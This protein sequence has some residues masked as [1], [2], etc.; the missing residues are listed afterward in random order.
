MSKVGVVDM[1]RVLDET[2]L[3]KQ[4]AAE[5]KA[6]WDERKAAYDRRRE[7]VSIPGG[8]P[9]EPEALARELQQL[10]V[11]AQRDLGELRSSMIK[12]VTQ[13]AREALKTLCAEKGVDVV[14]EKSAVVF[15]SDPAADLTAELMARLDAKPDTGAKPAPRK[16]R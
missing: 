13:K 4:H 5:L 12:D 3:G 10:D 2:Q 9:V 15:F 16:K 7:A 1:V 6:R 11:D 8:R 14:V